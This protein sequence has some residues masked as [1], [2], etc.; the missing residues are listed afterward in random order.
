MNI[1]I[2]GTRSFQNYKLLKYKTLDIIKNMDKPYAEITIF[3]GEAEGADKLAKEFAKERGFKMRSFP[4]EWNNL[5]TPRAIIKEG[6][7][8]HRYNARA[9]YDRNV[10]MAEAAGKESM[11]I[12]FWDGKS[13]G[14]RH[15]IEIAQDF[16]LTV[17]IIRF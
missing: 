8:G 1:I 7:Y 4:A 12:A 14:T 2:A 13:P 17:H 16:H 3:Q 5:L 15:M 10:K 11:L 9:G 6:R